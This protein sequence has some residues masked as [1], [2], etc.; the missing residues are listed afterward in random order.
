MTV[1]VSLF[2]SIPAIRSLHKMNNKFYHSTVSVAIVV[3]YCLVGRNKI[4][5]HGPEEYAH[6]DGSDLPSMQLP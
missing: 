4:S 3:S 2:L 1:V 5:A 6:N